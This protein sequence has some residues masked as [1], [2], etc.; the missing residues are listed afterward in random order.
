MG[1]RKFESRTQNYREGTTIQLHNIYIV[2]IIQWTI[3]LIDILERC[4]LLNYYFVPV[5]QNLVVLHVR[6]PL[7]LTDIPSGR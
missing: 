4:C 5:P 2:K 7:I 3:L 6:S 1:L